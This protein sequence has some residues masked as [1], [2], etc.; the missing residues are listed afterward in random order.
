MTQEPAR[1]ARLL[2]SLQEPRAR[3]AV[4]VVALV[5]MLPSVADRFA[6]DDHVLA[7]KAR[8][9]TG[10][11]GLASEPLWLFTFT[12]GRPADNQALMDQGVLL[13]WWSDPQHLNA[14]FRPLSSLTHLLDFQLW[15]HAP[16]LMHVHSLLWFA[17]LLVVILHLYRR[18]SPEPA[19]LPGFA[20]LLY[21]L[22]AAHGTTVGWISNRNALVS[23]AFALPAVFA[24]HR[25]RRHGGRLAGVVG[26]LCFALGLCAGETALAV[27]GY[28]VAY[29]VCLDRDALR[30]RL[31]ALAPYLVLLLAHRALYHFLGLGSFGS[32]GYH[33]PLHEPWAFARALA[34][35]L[36]VL[37]SAQLGAPTADVAFWGSL[38]ERQQ[39][40]VL[41]WLTLG[42]LGW[43]AAPLLRRSAQAR[44][45]AL[46][47]LLAAVPVSASIPGERL[48]LVV[49]VG[50]AAL[51]ALLI[52]AP[53]REHAGQARLQGLLL[54]GLVAAHLLAAPLGLVLQANSMNLV[55]AAV[56]R[57][58][59]SLGDAPDLADKSL[60]VV[61]A[62]VNILLSYLQL[63]R[64][65]RGAPHPAH[66]YWLASASSQISVMRSAERTLRVSLSR[67]FLEQ[68]EQTHYR[69][70]PSALG[71]GNEVQLS[72]LA[73]KVV[74]V[75]ADARPKTVD[76]SF[77]HRLD[78][79]R[80]LLRQYRDGKLWPWQP[81]TLGASER[82]S[83]ED[84]FRVVVS[85]PFR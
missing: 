61:N 55:A 46:G 3:V 20:F 59:A 1:L 18:L 57:V 54:A 12:T 25:V 34:Y 81:P 52:A 27:L 5:L 79:P 41:S 70:D 29:A 11:Q 40:Y 9:H 85:E 4:A 19:W 84:F 45:W 2:R 77:A 67:G 50:A 42:A 8:A 80:Y 26:P 14:F 10:V 78:S 82:F 22:D 66:V 49:G 56:D 75:T 23:A 65:H 63:A 64:L 15:P 83:A 44:F 30:A 53:L 28:L 62:P 36:P 37:L 39:L 7:L 21:A 13:P 6:L 48:L 60:V 69:S 31:M 73:V 32:A 24:H 68:P 76:F 35:N 17:V 43:L 71:V 51:V 38:A 72:E 33:D 74:E 47:M 16:R 58:D